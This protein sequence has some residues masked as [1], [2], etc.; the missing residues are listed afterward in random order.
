[1]VAFDGHT[2]QLLSLP[3]GD[4]C[5]GSQPPSV[6]SPPPAASHDTCPPGDIPED[7]RRI[8]RRILGREFR[9]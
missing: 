7:A 9:G 3:N 2:Y 8:L 6:P 4:P 5:K 1:L